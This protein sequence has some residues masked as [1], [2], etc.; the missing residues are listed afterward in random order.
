MT[1]S[2]IYL[3][4]DLLEIDEGL[5]DWEIEFIENLHQ[6]FREKDLTMKQRNRLVEI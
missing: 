5:S 2:Q 1:Q 4:Q 6:N 3:L